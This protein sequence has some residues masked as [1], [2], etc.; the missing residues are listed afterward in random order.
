M[1]IVPFIATPINGITL[2]KLTKALLPDC[3]IM[4]SSVTSWTV[5][6]VVFPIHFHELS[7]VIVVVVFFIPSLAVSKEIFEIIEFFPISFE[8]V[9]VTNWNPLKVVSSIIFFVDVVIVFSA[10][11]S[12]AFAPCFWINSFPPKTAVLVTNLAELVRYSSTWAFAFFFYCISPRQKN[13][14]FIIFIWI[15]S[16]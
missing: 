7:D 3:F 9:S 15:K 2:P 4:T 13:F 6:W 5:F 10:I 14:P 1:L 12:A 11:I 8:A 16:I